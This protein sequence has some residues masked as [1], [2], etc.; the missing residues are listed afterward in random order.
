[1]TKKKQP[2]PHMQRVIEVVANPLKAPKAKL[3]QTRCG[4]NRLFISFPSCYKAKRRG[5][6]PTQMPSLDRVINTIAIALMPTASKK[7]PMFFHPVISRNKM[8]PH[9]APT[10]PGPVVTN[11]NDTTNDN[12]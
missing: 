12:S 2:L 10:A 1:M 4:L 8:I 9:K 6:I 3:A 7:K 5:P 11:G